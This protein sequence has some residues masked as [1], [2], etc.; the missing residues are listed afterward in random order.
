[1]N[2]SDKSAFANLLGGLLDLYGRQLTTAAA[3]L[4]WGAFEAY[5]LDAVRASFSRYTQD[6]EQGRYPPTP[7][8]VLGFLPSTGT[9]RLSADEAWS[10][11]LSAFDEADTVCVTDEIL[12][13]VAAAS[14]VWESGDKIGA[15]M[16]FKSAYDR[17]VGERRQRGAAPVWRLSLGWDGER[18]TLAAQ[19]ALRLGRMTEDQVQAY[20]PAPP[21]AGP[22]A[23]IAGLL[24]GKVVAFPVDDDAL[25]RKRLAQLREAINGGES[26]KPASDPVAEREA[27]NRRKREAVEAIA[28]MQ[29]EREGKHG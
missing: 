24:S 14:P 20:L 25:T 27:F 19:E 10:L 16:T 5:P 18:R 29:S 26:R 22:A 2:Q 28:R 15:R 1:V 12:E 21:A 23:A 13:A 9:A 8:S 11:A 4:W 17:I 6:P 7:A 3:G